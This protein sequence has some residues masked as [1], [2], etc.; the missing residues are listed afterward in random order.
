MDKKPKSRVHPLIVCRLPHPPTNGQAI[1]FAVL[2]S[3]TVSFHFLCCL[4]T[5]HSSCDFA[6]TEIPLSISSNETSRPIVEGDANWPSGGV[7]FD[8]LAVSVSHSI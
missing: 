7:H 3:F 2:N 1:F 5:S 6:N 8:F 4:K